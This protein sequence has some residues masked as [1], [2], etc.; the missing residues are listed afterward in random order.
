MSESMFKSNSSMVSYETIHDDEEIAFLTFEDDVDLENSSTTGSST[1]IMAAVTTDNI[2]SEENHSPFYWENR[3]TSF[4]SSQ[5][6]P[7]EYDNHLKREEGPPP[8]L[9]EYKFRKES[10]YHFRST[11][12]IFMRYKKWK[13][14]YLVIDGDK[15]RIQKENRK[16]SIRIHYEFPILEVKC[17]NIESPFRVLRIVRP[18]SSDEIINYENMFESDFGKEIHEKQE[19]IIELRCSLDTTEDKKSYENEKA[20]INALMN[21]VEWNQ[22]I[23]RALCDL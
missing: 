12:T 4:I 1:D 5:T 8:S 6:H 14:V 10:M 7:E 16:N 13:K 19:M 18:E 2:D 9:G 15:I 22:S 3:N 20:K 11:G 17:Y 23:A 21:I